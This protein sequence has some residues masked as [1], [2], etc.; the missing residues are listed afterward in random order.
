M[1]ATLYKT[2]THHTVQHPLHV[3]TSQPEADIVNS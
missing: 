2:D 1:V 3:R